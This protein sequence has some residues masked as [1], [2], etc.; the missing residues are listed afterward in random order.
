MTKMKLNHHLQNIN[1]FHTQE[2]KDNTINIPGAHRR[3][4]LIILLAL[5]RKYEQNKSHTKNNK[6]IKKKKSQITP[7]IRYKKKK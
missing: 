5:K 1:K 2:K 4:H 6:T 3:K 7:K